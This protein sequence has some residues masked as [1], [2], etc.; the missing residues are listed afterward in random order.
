MQENSKIKVILHEST[1]IVASVKFH[2]QVLTFLDHL[3]PLKKEITFK[4]SLAEV[5]PSYLR[6][7]EGLGLF[8]AAD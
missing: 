8:S 3:W 2:M 7:S 4:S 5:A 6:E 1:E